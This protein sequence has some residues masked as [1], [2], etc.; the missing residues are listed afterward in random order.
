[1]HED[2]LSEISRWITGSV[3]NIFTPSAF[4]DW[5]IGLLSVTWFIVRPALLPIF[6]NSTFLSVHEIGIARTALGLT[7]IALILAGLLSLE[8]LVI[9]HSVRTRALFVLPSMVFPPL[10]WTW[11]NSQDLS[12]T[13]QHFVMLF[14]FFIISRVLILVVGTVASLSPF[15]ALSVFA[16]AATTSATTFSPSPVSPNRTDVLRKNIMVVVFDELNTGALLSSK[17]STPTIDGY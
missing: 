14:A 16:L 2:R 17:S 4:I 3:R 12:E 6:S 15:L 10:I 7:T 1:M 9:R 8:Y 5:R 11:R 13:L